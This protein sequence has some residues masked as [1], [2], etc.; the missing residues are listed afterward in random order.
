[1]ADWKEPLGK[2]LMKGLVQSRLT[3]LAR[4]LLGGRGAIL[5]L[6]R[7]T[8]E[9]GTRFGFNS[10]LTVDPVFLDQLLREMKK[11]EFIFMTLDEAVD[12]IADETAGRF[13]VITLDDGFRDNLVEALPVFERHGTPFTVF[14]APGLIDGSVELW[15]ELVEA[16]VTATQDPNVTIELP[17]G[18]RAAYNCSTETARVTAYVEICRL[19]SETLAEED[20][21]APVRSLAASA[22]IDATAFRRKRLMD[23]DEISRIASSPLCTIGAHTVHHY[24]LK[25]LRAD[26][27]L[28]E[29]CASADI[30]DERLGARPRH[31]AY[32]YGYREAVGKREA[33]LAA[34]AGFKTA[35]T[36]RHGVIHK[37]HAGH[38]RCLPR[39]SVNGRYQDIDYVNAM[40]SGL[41]TP[42]ANLGKT[43][44]TV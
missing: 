5:M 6:H 21:V 20:Q 30:L 31:F 39:I 25:R 10:H 40:L 22:G 19:L 24:N 36:T 37:R 42:I 8:A 18:G 2:L 41:T 3:A 43:V 4:P 35:L 27:A 26:A 14:I 1:M 15:W 28:Q 34:E 23:W 13:A 11:Q 9:P 38:L 7:V 29:M 32:P 17:G 44:V 33:D 12:C 16:A